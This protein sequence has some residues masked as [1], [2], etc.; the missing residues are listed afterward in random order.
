MV[1]RRWY[2]LGGI[3]LLAGTMGLM[4]CPITGNQVKTGGQT[5]GSKSAMKD[6]SGETAPDFTLQ[7]L[8]GQS[9]SLSQYKGKVVLL[10]FWATW[11]GP[12]KKEFPH[13]QR[14]L[15]KYEAK[16][17]KILAVSIDDA[18]QKSEVGPTVYR[19]GYSFTVLHDAEKRVVSLFN[20]KHR[21]PYSVL[22]GKKGQI[23]WRHEGYHPGDEV[24]MEKKIAS[25]LQE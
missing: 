5:G 15:K 24:T 6:V 25:L 7:D 19:Y 2:R 20:P 23:R 18:R 16:G 12:C 21:A 9:H 14:F 11:C 4:G 22:V 1:N 8:K 13:F 17:F 3:A 10:N